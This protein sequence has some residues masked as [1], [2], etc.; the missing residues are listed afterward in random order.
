MQKTILVS[1]VTIGLLAS[2]IGVGTYA[3]FSDTETSSGNTITAGTLDL[4][5]WDPGLPGWVDDPEV[6]E[7]VTITDIKPSMD[8]WSAPI[9]LKT[10]DN[11]AKFYKMITGV[12]CTPAA[13][14]TIEPRDDEC[15]YDPK[16]PTDPD[17]LA[18]I[19]QKMTEYMWFDLKVNDAEVIPDQSKLLGSLEGRW[20]YLGAYAAGT[21]VKVE[22]SFHLKNVVTNWAQGQQCTF[23]EQ[24]LVLQQ[25]DPTKPLGPGGACVNP[26]G[27]GCPGDLTQ[28][29]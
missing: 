14:G 17:Y 23:D 19:N 20:I 5:V 3:Y 6:P 10:V 22:Q 13:V 25:N 1:L 4:K 12:V 29:P 16:T 21:E 27:D 9:Y 7:L 18:C 11:P 28:Q 2:V 8:K 15:G 24:F 26:F